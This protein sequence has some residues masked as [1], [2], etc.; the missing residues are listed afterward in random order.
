MGSSEAAPP[1]GPGAGSSEAAPCGKGCG[2]GPGLVSTVRWTQSN[3]PVP[4]DA[5]PGCTCIVNLIHP[6]TFE[7]VRAEIQ[8]PPGPILAEKITVIHPWQRSDRLCLLLP[9]V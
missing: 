7:L 9:W 4:A 3:H 1:Q 6:T 2:K 8:L 5:V